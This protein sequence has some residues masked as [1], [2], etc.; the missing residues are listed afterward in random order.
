MLNV[1]SQFIDQK[2]SA[3]LPSNL[4]L[5]VSSVKTHVSNPFTENGR[6]SRT[7]AVEKPKD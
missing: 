6:N 3:R 7:K 1:K 5:S 2:D 4:F